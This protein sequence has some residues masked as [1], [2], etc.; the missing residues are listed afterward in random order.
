LLIDSFTFSIL[1]Q[2]FCSSLL[3]LFWILFQAVS[4]FLFIYLDFCVSSLFLHLCSISLPFHYIFFKLIM[5]E[6]SFSQASRKVE[7]F[8]WRRLNS[9]FLFV[10]AL[11]SLVQWF[12]WASYRVRF[13]VSLCL[14]FLWWA[15]L[16]EVI[17]L[18][19]DDWVCIF[20]LFAI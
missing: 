3:S 15:R 16:S 17:I 7:F 11:L 6:V 19:T 14:F 9:F 12:V 4:Y 8:P 13:V 10:S 2:G 20:V 5:F 1:F 18:S